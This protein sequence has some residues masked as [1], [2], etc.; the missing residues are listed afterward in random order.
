[1]IHAS[2]RP[3]SRSVPVCSRK[4]LPLLQSWLQ[5]PVRSSWPRPS[6][7]CPHPPLPLSPAPPALQL[8]QV[9]RLSCQQLVPPGLVWAK[10]TAATFPDFTAGTAAAGG[11]LQAHHPTPSPCP[12]PTPAPLIK[13]RGCGAY[14]PGD[15]TLAS[16]WRPSAGGSQTA[17]PGALGL[18]VGLDEAPDGVHATA[19]P[20]ACACPW[21]MCTTTAASSRRWF[22]TLLP[23]SPT[24]LSSQTCLHRRPP[25]PWNPRSQHSALPDAA[26]KAHSL[27]SQAPTLA[28]SAAQ[29]Q[30]DMCDILNAAKVQQTLS[31][32]S[33]LADFLAL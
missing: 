30:H 7:A 20:T 27:Q 11:S 14:A 19:C 28:A 23:R 9:P 13:P 16:C 25:P 8:H 29:L 18:G 3:P 26:A 10:A 24:A 12:R 17:G 21:T 6:T 4:S 31:A 32:A 22:Q 15:T 2:S 33:R 1:M 5:S